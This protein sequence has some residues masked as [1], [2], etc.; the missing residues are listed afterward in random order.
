MIMQ[1]LE[2]IGYKNVVIVGGMSSSSCLKDYMHKLISCSKQCSIMILIPSAVTVLLLQVSWYSAFW[3]PFWQ[4]SL[5]ALCSLSRG[6]RRLQ[7]LPVWLH[8]HPEQQD[9]SAFNWEVLSLPEECLWGP[10][11]IPQDQQSEKACP[12][13]VILPRQWSSALIRLQCYWDD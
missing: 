12:S 4:V 6:P 10:P 13:G 3:L 7:S 5:P 8:S 11:T 2:V 9:D 1:K